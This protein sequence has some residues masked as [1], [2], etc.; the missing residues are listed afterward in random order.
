MI[1]SCPSNTYCS[2]GYCTGQYYYNY[3]YYNYPY[4]YNGYGT[5]AVNVRDCNNNN[6]VPATVQVW[7]GG[8][9]QYSATGTVLFYGLSQGTYTIS[10]SSAGYASQS[11]SQTVYYNQQT[12]AD[13]CLNRNVAIT[14]Q[15]TGE[16]CLKIK[17]LT[18]DG[19][20]KSGETETFQASINNCGTFNEYSI[21]TR[22]KMFET[23]ADGSIISL[24]PGETKTVSIS[25]D[26]PSSAAGR[27][28]A[29]LEIS[30]ADNS[31]STEKTF[32]I[33]FGQPVLS[34]KDQ[35]EAKR[36]EINSFSFDLMNVGKATETF[37]LSVSGPAKDWIHFSPDTITVDAGD[38]VTVSG[39]AAVPCDAKIGDYIFTINAKDK[40]VSSQTTSLRVIDGRSWI[41]MLIFPEFSSYEIY[42]L[43]LVVLILILFVI[44]AY[45]LWK[46]KGKWVWIT[47]RKL[48][49]EPEAMPKK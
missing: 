24:A 38:R 1:I 27:E 12:S 40:T 15:P 41:G 29:V 22:L 13:I 35:Y 21:K 16:H 32:N 25:I 37:T 26:V 44:I 49:G 33:L 46:R 34:V 7:P 18:S 6:F 43:G 9:S 2:G 17:S 19:E 30:N 20:I 14:T 10:A 3:P 31:L 11:G 4:N 42:L 8:T 47:Q 39:I 5:L 48:P 23:S 28:K 45:I 36:C